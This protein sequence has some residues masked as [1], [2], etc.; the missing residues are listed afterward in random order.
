MNT[1]TIIRTIL[2]IATCLN[3][4][5]MA[6]DLAQ[7]NNAKLDLAYRIVSVI[8]NFI[9]VACVTWFNNDYTPEACEGTGLTRMLKAE[10]D[11]IGVNVDGLDYIEDGDDDE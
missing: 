3:T 4:A 1:G 9:I 11:E 2:A 5:L 7:F 8:L 6:T 10:E